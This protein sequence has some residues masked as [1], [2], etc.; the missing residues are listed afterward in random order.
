MRSLTFPLLL[1]CV[2][3]L[4]S[5]SQQSAPRP[6]TSSKA[7]A[8]KAQPSAAP[9]GKPE[10]MP[11]P[12]PDNKLEAGKVPGSDK[13]EK[14]VHFDMTEVP[15]AVTHHEITLAGRVLRYTATAGRLPIKTDDGR[16][17]AE[18]FFVGYAAEG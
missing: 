13:P 18:M 1:V 6:E 15:P 3:G 7:P 2:L 8:K 14:D 5:F 4:N 11:P 16:I 10:E 12:A 17:E 9:E